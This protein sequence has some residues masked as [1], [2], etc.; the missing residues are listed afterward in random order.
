MRAYNQEQQL[1]SNWQPVAQLHLL[2]EAIAHSAWGLLDSAGYPPADS[3]CW[4]GVDSNNSASCVTLLAVSA[5]Q[6]G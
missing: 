5:A 6:V 4:S 2:L 1:G 3:T